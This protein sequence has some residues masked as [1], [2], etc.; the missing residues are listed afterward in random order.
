MQGEIYGRLTV[1]EFSHKDTR[2]RKWW[3]CKCICGNETILHTGNLHSGNTR[4]CGCLARD[5][6]KN[7]RIAENYSEVTA[8]ILGYKRHASKRNLIW[9]LSRDVVVDLILAPCHYCGTMKSNTKITKNTVNPLQYNGIDRK[10]N[11]I[12]YTLDNT[13][14]CCRVCNRAKSSMKYDDFISWCNAIS[15]FRSNL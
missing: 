15:Q 11:N 1:V 4:S 3:R 10:D 6:K 8:V 5:Q 14:S 2:S 7:R 9:S 12:G 13:V